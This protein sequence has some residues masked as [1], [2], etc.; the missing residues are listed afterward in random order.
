MRDRFT[1]LGVGIL[2]VGMSAGTTTG[3]PQT[4]AGGNKPSIEI[5]RMRQDFGEVFERAKYE[6]SFVVRNRG[7]ADLVIEDVKPG[8]GCTVAKFDKVIAPGAEGKI[9]LVLN[10]DQ[11]SGEFAKTAVV[12]TNDPEHPELTLTIAGKEIPF[13]NIAPAGTIYLHG[14][15]DEAVEKTVTISSNEK[16]FALAVTGVTSN[17]DDKITYKVEPA[18]K[19]GEFVLRVAK[20]T[21]I[22]PSSAY[23]NITIKTNS[24]KSPETVVQ[25]HV[26]VKGSISVTP[27]TLNYGSVKFG[28][29]GGSGEPVTKTVM[30]LKTD[31]QFEVKGAVIDNKN[32]SA[33]IEPVEPG[34]Q[35]KVEVTFVPP[36][37]TSPTQRE[38][39][40]LLIN[41]SDP[42][43]PSVKVHLVARAM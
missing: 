26:M 27:Q 43:E 2:I 23:G 5:P 41:T 36:S 35:Y 14:R 7:K 30:I 15:Y 20:K 1:W 18:P 10:G 4:A 29:K 38:V 37:K 21:D 42:R 25:V 17:I 6:Y 34:K 40:E 12:R 11:V 19:K 9:E 32:F 16:E 28:A 24:E 22:P 8:C 3:S 33:K 13:L 39:G 31:G